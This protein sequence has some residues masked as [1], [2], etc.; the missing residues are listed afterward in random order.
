M[1]KFMHLSRLPRIVGL[2]AALLALPNLAAISAESS[3]PTVPS[4]QIAALT[5]RIDA[6]IGQPRFA[7]ATWG[8][9]IT[10]L[11]SGRTVYAHNADTLLTPASTAKLFTAVLALDSLGKDYRVSTRLRARGG[12]KDGRLDGT[13]VLQGQGDPTLG[14]DP[15]SLDW[16]ERLADAVAAAGIHDIH[17]D[18]VADDTYFATPSM[19][20]GWEAIDLQSYFATTASAL[21]VGENVVEASVS[22]GARDGS[23]VQIAFDPADAAP[24]L[25]NRMH[26]TAAD[27]HADINIYRAAG[28]ARLYAFGGMPVRAP[29]QR[30][31]LSVVDPALLAAQRLERALGRRGI[32][33]DGRVRALHWPDADA[34]LTDPALPVLAQ[35]DSPPVADIVRSALKRSQ[36]LYMQNLLLIS[37][38]KAQA[39]DA[40]SGNASPGFATTE[41]WGIKAMNGMLAR[42]GISPSATL[43]EEGT[44]LSRRDLTTPGALTKLL[45]YMHGQPDADTFRDSLPVAGVDGTLMWRMR[46]TPAEGNVHAK[47]GSMAYTHALAGY[48]TSAA[49]EPFA[50]AI[51]LNNYQPPTR[52]AVALP[53]ASADVDAIA[54]MLAGLGR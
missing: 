41:Y 2:I 22:P 30:L 23:P 50:F 18:L 1:Q 7:A 49:G 43:L 35:I 34:R 32:R 45:V 20:S 17:G 36:N 44:G 9:Q 5:T 3:P 47:T 11:D 27:I 10:S 42:L 52:S 16:A 40:Q 21:S 31:R 12:I 46:G 26:T 39:D 29:A 37:G 25:D 51:V 24:A 4:A 13:L 38:A 15:A 14:V 54:E 6:L 33:I 19:G 48:V 53:S 8:I 28:D